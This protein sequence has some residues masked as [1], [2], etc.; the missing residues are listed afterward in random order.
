MAEQGG[1]FTLRCLVVVVAFYGVI[2]GLC[3]WPRIQKPTIGA[4]LL[5][6]AMASYFISKYG[7]YVDSE[8]IRNAMQTD[9]AEATDL[10]GASFAGWML[11]LFCIPALLLWRT[12]VAYTAYGFKSALLHLRMPAICLIIMFATLWSGMQEFA[13]FYRNHREVRHMITPYNA[14]AA[15]I[16]YTRTDLLPKPAKQMHIASPSYHAPRA[17]DAPRNVVVLVV[18]ETARAANFSLGGYERETNPEL[19]NRNDIVYFDQ[20]TSCGTHTAYSLPCMFSSLSRKNFSLDKFSQNDDLMSLVAGAGVTSIW[21][22]NN[23][24]CKGVCNGME[25]VREAD[26]AKNYPQHCQS[27]ECYD[28]ALVEALKTAL[29]RKGDLFIVLH[30]KGSHGPLYHKRV[31]AEFA[32][33]QPVCHQADLGKCSDQEITN[34]YDNTILY[35]DHV[36]NGLIEALGQEQ[37][38]ALFYSSDHGESLGEK[39]MYL[40]GA[41]YMLAPSEQTHI[42]AVMWLSQDMRNAQRIEWACLQKQA[43]VPLS[44]DNIFATLLQLN[45]VETATRKEADS[46]LSGCRP[47]KTVSLQAQ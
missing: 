10:M 42:P 2:L 43:D 15:V 6:G 1:M 35:T 19:Q 40:H 25:I 12:N 44:H 24:G 20:F 28:G 27:G 5:I 4:L 14:I 3:A 29:K 41:P 33:F 22:D 30:Q 36:L 38:A 46:I 16:K 8:M 47:R 37:S 21:V 39:G 18:G 11:A 13:P 32:Q 9:H 26:L 34:A 17:Q 45:Q 7:I 31:P 23:S